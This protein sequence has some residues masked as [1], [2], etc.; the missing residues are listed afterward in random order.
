MNDTFA[1]RL[2][3]TLRWFAAEL[4]PFPGRGQFALRLTLASAIA[5][6]IG[7]TFQI[8]YTVLSLV[9]VFFTAQANV[10]LTR[11]IFIVLS[12]ADFI[13]VC[14]FVFLLKLT[15][16]YALLRIIAS[17]V[18]FFCFMF[19][20]RVSK[21]GLVLLGPALVVLYAQSFVDQ[22][23]QADYLVRQVL[24]SVGAITYGSVLALIVNTVFA[25]TNPVRQ[26]EGEA[27]RQLGRAAA[28]LGALAAG[29]TAAPPLS[30]G[31]L[32]RQSA[33]LQGFAT[34]ANMADAKDPAR[35]QYRQCCVAAVLHAQH[36]CN[37]LPAV[38]PHATPV[39][40]R[41]L[42]RLQAQ[43]LAFDAAIAA[44]TSF[45]PEWTPDAPER[46][47]LATL[48]QAD[49][50][51]RTLQAVAHFDSAAVPAQKPP[52]PPLVPPDVFTNP[53]Y[54]RFAV[55]V[56]ICGLTGYFV[57][58]VLQWPGIHTILIT[59]GMVALPGL[60][61]SVRQMT[62]RFYGALL[63]SVSALLVFVLVMPYI[64]TIFGLLL[65]MLPV[66]AAG[67]WLTA[68]SERLAYVGTQGA[69]TFAL[70]L[71]EH[72]G[73][74][75][76][77]TEIRDRMVGILL[78]VSICWV[79]YVFIWP[80]SES[81]AT[82]VKLAALVRALAELVRSPAR[83][84]DPQQ[85][86]AYA[87]QHMQCWAALNACSMDLEKVRY[88]PRYKRGAP[89]RLAAQAER[90]LAVS[91]DLLVRQDHV[92]G[93]TLAALDPA[94]ARVTTAPALATA[95]RLRDETASLLDIYA[96]RVVE[97]GEPPTREQE[98]LRAH[99][100]QIAGPA[101]TPLLAHVQ[102]LALAAADLPGWETAN[103]TTTAGASAIATASRST[104]NL[105]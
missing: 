104:G 2:A 26:F 10:V 48:A 12:L 15:Y 91:R 25:S 78:G 6:V 14:V 88:E 94:Q 45:R 13:A 44:H 96:K 95:A 82:R 87:K 58:N 19:C 36:L 71:L 86:I 20:V 34:F 43:L 75:T 72:F 53:A 4:A 74:S 54:V 21:A 52:R 46:A 62:L 69:A 11:V 16:D 41:A 99:A 7:E 73:P 5:I 33:A 97:Q 59:S 39:L 105:P 3:H 80:E 66:I 90:L 51:Y 9:A 30:G 50:L 70:A 35:Q 28:R 27:H 31:E 22:T 56:L 83:R 17:G 32:Q 65:A 24:W 47:A 89:A 67:A 38:L 102:R 100:M 61:T 68:G 55:K 1:Q 103:S 85:Q 77:L 60:G 29:E 98:Q 18:L 84:D 81:G 64:D 49:D 92:H 76:D 37:T 79:V 101:D 63:G 40:R 23:G 42:Q 8:P 57:F 93:E